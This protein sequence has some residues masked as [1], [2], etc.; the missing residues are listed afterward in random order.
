MKEEGK[1]L[2]LWDWYS[3]RQNLPCAHC[4]VI[5][6]EHTIAQLETCGL[7]LGILMP[8]LTA[9]ELNLKTPDPATKGNDKLPFMTLE[10]LRTLKERRKQP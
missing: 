3:P 7:K 1:P 9:E 8:F 6:S 5:L 4:R 2:K 10:E